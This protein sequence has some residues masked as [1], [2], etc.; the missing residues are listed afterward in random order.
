M[1]NLLYELLL[2]P[3]LYDLTTFHH[4]DVIR[5]GNSRQSM[6]YHDDSLPAG[7]SP[8]AFLD[9]P[10]GLAVQAAHS[11]VHDDDFCIFLHQ[12]PR[13]G[14]VLHLSAGEPLS[15]LANLCLVAIGPRQDLDVD[16][17]GPARVLDLF[18][19]GSEITVAYV[20]E[21]RLGEYG[22]LLRHYGDLLAQRLEPQVPEVLAVDLDRARRDVVPAGEELDDGG[23]A[24]P[25]LA[26][27]RHGATSLDMETCIPYCVL[28][29]IV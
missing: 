27:E 18:L 10:V 1:A 4:Q 14:Q 26:H 3:G 19:R 24:A 15:R 23:L 12:H 5:V 17:S 6:G 28:V 9:R 11:L 29:L 25:G 22:D 7:P 2:P 20:E 21:D 8:E 13:D 16:G